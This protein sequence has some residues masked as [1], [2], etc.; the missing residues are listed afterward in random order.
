MSPVVTMCDAND[1]LH[2]KATTVGRIT[3]MIET[4]IIN[5]ET[6]EIVPWGESGEVCSR[7]YSV[8]RGYWGDE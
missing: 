6:G 5:T 4:K 7:G 3:P 8:M 1:P 2:K